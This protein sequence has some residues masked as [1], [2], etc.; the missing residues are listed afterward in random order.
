M[1]FTE[2]GERVMHCNCN[3]RMSEN[4]LKSVIDN[5]YHLT[6]KFEKIYED[7]AE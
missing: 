6:E 7:D 5:Y 2:N 1:L 3:K 4:E